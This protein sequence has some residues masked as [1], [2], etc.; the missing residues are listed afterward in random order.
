MDLLRYLIV[1]ETSQQ[2]SSR[3]S[4]AVESPPKLTTNSAS[5]DSTDNTDSSLHTKPASAS[6][7]PSV[8]DGALET[9]YRVLPASDYLANGAT[10]LLH[11][12]FALSQK[13]ARDAR[14]KCAQKKVV[15]AYWHRYGECRRDPSSHTYDG[16]KDICPYLHNVDRDRKDLKVQHVSHEQGRRKR[17]QAAPHRR[18][19][20]AQRHSSSLLDHR[21]KVQTFNNGIDQQAS[22]GAESRGKK[23]KRNSG[24]NGDRQQAKVQKQSAPAIVSKATGR[25]GP[26]KTCFFW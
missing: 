13:P 15:C 25:H 6:T 9:L 18:E 26:Q 17:G 23:R 22:G 10:A 8:V 7:P 14:P 3:S 1:P 5:G 2:Y 4:V 16:S 24:D 12:T 20:P 21:P 11:K 19:Q